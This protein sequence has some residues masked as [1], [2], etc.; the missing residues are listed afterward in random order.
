MWILFFLVSHLILSIA[1][2]VNMS[3]FPM[4]SHNSQQTIEPFPDKFLSYC[5]AIM[6]NKNSIDDSINLHRS[7]AFWQG[8]GMHHP[9]K[10]SYRFL[11]IHIPRRQTSLFQMVVCLQKNGE[12]ARNQMN[13]ASILLY[14]MEITLIKTLRGFSFTP[15]FHPLLFTSTNLMRKNP[16][17]TMYLF[18]SFR[19][20]TISNAIANISYIRTQDY[21]DFTGSR[22]L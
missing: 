10:I 14:L 2:S 7:F 5:T 12:K 13:G 3:L 1:S 4:L 18:F 19:T 11:L 9:V 16:I 22:F 15:T 17:F 8:T 20:L 21:T 6:Q